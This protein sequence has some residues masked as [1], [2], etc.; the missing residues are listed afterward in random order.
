MSTLA[1]DIDVSSNADEV[2]AIMGRIGERI[3]DDARIAALNRTGASGVTQIRKDTATATGVPSKEI[4][5]R[6]KL[7][8]ASKRVRGARIFIGVLPVAAIKAGGRAL[9]NGVSYR[10]AKGEGRVKIKSGFLATMPTGHRG[11]FQ[12]TGEAKRV[13]TKGNYQGQRREPIAEVKIQIAPTARRNAERFVRVDAPRLFEDRYRHEF[14]FRV[15]RE[16]DRQ[17]RAR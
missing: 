10:G 9:A 16:I 11:I 1:F 14:E 15:Q 7:H 5:K 4:S 13:M 17:A 12:R 8:R 3:V 6:M 2:A